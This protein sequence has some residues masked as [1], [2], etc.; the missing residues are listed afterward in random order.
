MGWSCL[1]RHKPD[2]HLLQLTHTFI[3][4][5]YYNTNSRNELS[6]I[7]IPTIQQII[8]HTYIGLCPRRRSRIPDS[9]PSMAPSLTLQTFFFST[10]S[11]AHR[12]TGEKLS[13]RGR[14]VDAGYSKAKG[15]ETH[16]I[17]T[18]YDIFS[19][20]QYLYFSFTITSYHI[21]DSLRY[22]IFKPPQSISY[23]PSTQNF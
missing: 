16:K 4:T 22:R 18:K 7:M 1:P 11:Q 14:V 10:R 3:L 13:G 9:E 2:R 23:T 19:I 21:P 15:S 8:T 12:T 6:I 20:I 5:P 17:H